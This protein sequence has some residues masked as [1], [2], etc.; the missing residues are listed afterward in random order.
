MVEKHV[1]LSQ[2]ILYCEKCNYTCYKKNDYEKHLLTKK[3]NILKTPDDIYHTYYGGF[4]RDTLIQDNGKLN[5]ISR[6]IEQGIPENSNVIGVIEIED[7]EV[8]NYK[9]KNVAANKCLF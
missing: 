1:D 7:T 8:I 9:Y 6:Y 4:G 5:P 2:N 3:H